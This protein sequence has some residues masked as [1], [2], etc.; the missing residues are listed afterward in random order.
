MKLQVRIKG[1]TLVSL[2]DTGSTHTFIKEGLLTQLGLS[3]TT[4]EGL[5]VKVANGERVTSGGVC[6]AMDMDIGS[7]HFSTNFYVLPLDGRHC[8]G[9]PMVAHIGTHLVGL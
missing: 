7:E 6:R 5:T 2:V 1:T 3:V 9:H 8:L 4:R